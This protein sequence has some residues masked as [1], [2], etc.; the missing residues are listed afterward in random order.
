MNLTSIHFVRP[1]PTD[2]SKTS[3]QMVSYVF[4]EALKCDVL[5]DIFLFYSTH[6]LFFFFL[7]ITCF[8][9]RFH[10]TFL[11]YPADCVLIFD[12]LPPH[13]LMRVI[14]LTIATPLT[15]AFIQPFRKCICF[16]CVTAKKNVIL[17]ETS[18]LHSIAKHFFLMNKISIAH[19]NLGS[20]FL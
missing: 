5:F 1:S 2:I 6:S 15:V 18:H 10:S 3:S 20:I 11:A 4:L 17:L 8:E 13:H 16:S 7:K 14:G 9:F 12:L 19:Q